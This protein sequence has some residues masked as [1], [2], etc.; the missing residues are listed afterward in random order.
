MVSIFSP[1]VAGTNSLLMKRP[2]CG[3]KVVMD[4]LVWWWWWWVCLGWEWSLLTGWLGVFG[5]VWGCELEGFGHDV[6]SLC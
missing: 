5:A 6:Q 2:C 3:V 4:K 1:E